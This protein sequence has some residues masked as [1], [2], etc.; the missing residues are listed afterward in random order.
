MKQRYGLN[1]IIMCFMISRDTP[2][3]I[4]LRKSSKGAWNGREIC[5]SFL[6]LWDGT[7]ENIRLAF[8]KSVR[9]T[10]K[11]CN[12]QLLFKTFFL[13]L[14]C[15]ITWELRLKFGQESILK[16]FRKFNCRVEV[17]KNNWK[18]KME[19]FNPCSPNRPRAYSVIITSITEG[20]I[21]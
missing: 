19:E 11:R 2:Q 14:K 8:S 16:M 15:L 13:P 1:Y 20:P 3:Q 12:E 4:L 7:E 21:A 5:P 18:R 9:F 17:A 10:K 6:K